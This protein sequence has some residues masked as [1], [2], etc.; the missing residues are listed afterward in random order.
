MS[1]T[2]YAIYYLPPRGA[3]A[4]FGARWLGWDVQGGRRAPPPDL[5]G[6]DDV[7]M[8]PRKYGFHGTLKPPFRLAERMTA[9]DLGD[10]VA[11]LA[12]GCAPARTRGLALSCLGGFLALT[13][14]GDA[15]GIA[16]VAARCV[17]GL[18]R[19]R[20]PPPP[21]ELA[22][23]RKAGLSAR[24]EALLTRW[25]YPYVLDEFR[26]HL[27]LSGRLPEDRIDHWRQV[28]QARLPDLPDPFTLDAVALV[29][30]RQD[31]HFETIHR[32]ALAG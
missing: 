32:Y 24:Q 6:L 11:A 5:P 10:A 9:E 30:E 31:G 17:T 8:T 12:E 25:G 18:D 21:E 19:F 26:F 1:Y 22:R 7:T 23:R 27:T 16:R 13:P 28:L 2:R 15:A 29:G 3:L 20:A 14:V 4:D